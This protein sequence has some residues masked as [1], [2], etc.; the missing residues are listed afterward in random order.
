M[1]ERVC[2]FFYVWI[3]YQ[4]CFII[5]IQVKGESCFLLKKTTVIW[6][7]KT[8]L[9]IYIHL[10][11]VH[12]FFQICLWSLQPTEV[13]FYSFFKVHSWVNWNRASVWKENCHWLYCFF[14]ISYNLNP[15]LVN[16]Y[17]MIPVNLLCLNQ[18]LKSN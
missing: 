18:I 6:I 3:Y 5:W 8:A 13:K 2:C 10:V 7:P 9:F 12:F 4:C 17:C 14:L 11:F 15:C 16:K 1:D